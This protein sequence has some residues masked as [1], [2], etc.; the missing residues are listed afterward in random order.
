MVVNHHY[1]CYIA[2][3]VPLATDGKAD[4]SGRYIGVIMTTHR[5]SH[6]EDWVGLRRGGATPQI[7]LGW[8]RKVNTK[9]G[10]YEKNI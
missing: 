8:S 1:V 3:P 7:F 6:V 4:G 5:V 9:G 10:D 2:Q